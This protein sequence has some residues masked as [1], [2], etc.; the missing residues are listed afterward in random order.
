MGGIALAQMQ[1]WIS[2]WAAGASADYTSV[3]GGP[4]GAFSWPP[5][6]ETQEVQMTPWLGLGL[7]H[8]PFTF[9]PYLNSIPRALFITAPEAMQIYLDFYERKMGEGKG[10]PVLAIPE[11]HWPLPIPYFQGWGSVWQKS[12]QLVE[13]ICITWSFECLHRL[14]GCFVSSMKGNAFIGLP[15]TKLVVYYKKSYN[16]N[17]I[18]TY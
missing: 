7:A 1:G 10:S 8:Y 12:A 5:C 13:V 3:G 14:S 16:N 4:P 15:V 2:E 9:Y 17:K 11:N 18:N 6:H